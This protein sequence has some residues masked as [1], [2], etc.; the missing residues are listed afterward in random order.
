MAAELSTLHKALAVEARQHYPNL[1]GR[2]ARFADFV[3]EQIAVLRL[4]LFPNPSVMGR[5]TKLAEGFARYDDLSAPERAALVEGMVGL[6]PY[7]GAERTEAALAAP[8]GELSPAAM[9]RRVPRVQEELPRY[10]KP[11]GKPKEAPRPKGEGLDQSVQFV[12][13]VGP[14][15]AERLS[16]LGILTVWDLLHHYPRTHLDYQNRTPIRDLV[17]GAKVT[18]WGTIRKVEAFSPPRRP[19]MSIL[20]VAISD[21]SGTVTA[22]WFMG[23]ANKFQLELQK[24]RFPVG[25]QVLLSGEV[26]HDEYTGRM[27]FD[28]PE[29]ELLGEGGDE[30]SESL[31]VGRIV[32]VYSL[33]EGL[34]LK[35]LRNAIHEALETFGPL[36][37]DPLPAAMVS[38]QG[39][40]DRRSAL[41][42]LHFPASMA[43]KDTARARLVFEELFWLQLGLAYRR[44][45]QRK[46]TES[47]ALPA[48]GELT[49]RLIQAL[50]FTL[51]RAQTRVFDEIRADLAAPKPMSRLVQGDVGSGKTVVALLSLLVAVENGY[52]GALMAPTEILAEQHYKKFAE[53]LAP[54]GI[55]CALLL[56]KQ[57]KRER[58]QY[59]RAIA[60]GYTPVVVGTHALIQ[61]GVE[62]QK[63]G[64]VVI[65]E[66]H[67]FGVKQRAL[68]RSKG[69]NPEVLTMTA[70]PIPRTLALT[71]HGDLDVSVIDELPPGRKPIQTSWVTAKGRKAAWELIRRELGQGRQAYIV[72]PLIEASE[73]LENVRAATEEAEEL[74]HEVFPDF[75]VGL[76][77]GQMAP[78]E[79]EAVVDAFRRHDLD[80]LVATTV[81]EV[82]VDVP[83][84]SVMVIENA[85][86]FGLSQLHQLRGRVGRG[87]DQSY[88][89]LVSSA[90][91]E[92]TRQRMEVMVATNDGF[93]IAEQDLKLRGPGE[94]LGTRQSGL[95]DFMLAD[96]TSD[97]V[98]LEKARQYAF[99]VIEAD[100]ELE[101]HPGLKA[102]LFRHFQANLS[103]LG[104]G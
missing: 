37:T 75:R 70:T 86:R 10:E 52:Q 66:Q 104:A 31:H 56:G 2:S 101:R 32:P 23:K 48:N 57:G 91:S 19:T 34:N 26:R 22:R 38:E 12:K 45:Q 76:L 51:T 96:I 81:I 71:L 89:V 61:D 47:I 94:F 84:A 29:V 62:F 17:V 69:Q 30:D 102:D 7:L 82:G 60:T 36:L 65:D 6:L 77:H 73:E 72:F 1:Q 97:T 90:T 16:K 20:T 68:L 54:L 35:T 39:F 18:L 53:W 27:H 95:P 50:P 40:L 49:D 64:L 33:T 15:L 3:C 13:G 43:E 93:V 9:A 24:K 4:T 41:K 79:K 74:Q 85:E 25:A 21:G 100:P 14:R 103:F 46:Q 83:N 5:L 88:C 59:L 44:A 55:P 67:R 58:T 28:R 80:I 63:L 87:A 42:S 8:H 92:A 78:D 99:Q 98:W 11:A